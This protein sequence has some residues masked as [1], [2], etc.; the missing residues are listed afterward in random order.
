M[1]LLDDTLDNLKDGDYVR[2]E[3]FH[4]DKPY[5]L[6][7]IVAH[8]ADGLLRLIN[9]GTIGAMN[10]D[11]HEYMA[12]HGV[13]EILQLGHYDR[14][15]RWTPSGPGTM[16]GAE[17]G[18]FV[19]YAEYRRALTRRAI[20]ILREIRDEALILEGMTDSPIGRA[21]LALIENRLQ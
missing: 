18:D 9:V 10:V 15:V 8:N 1:T 13:T 11:S 17:Q 20:P 12:K 4:E 7:G 14:P 6:E 21:F 2:L 19:T 16:S 3:G 5:A